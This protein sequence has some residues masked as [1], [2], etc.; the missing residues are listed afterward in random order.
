ME[1]FTGVLEKK[2]SNMFSN[3]LQDAIMITTGFSIE[4]CSLESEGNNSN[5]IVGAMVMCGERSVILTIS[6][7]DLSARNIV[8]YMTGIDLCELKTDMLCD[9]ITEIVNIIGGGARIAL[10][11]TEL[12]ISMTVP[13]TI[14]GTD[15][16]IVVKKRTERIIK[17]FCGNNIKLCLK[18]FEL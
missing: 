11:N 18:I 7:D 5:E 16:D 9:G 15:L 6:T 2:W 3:L 8:S 13:F 1:K 12:A 17:C 14:V 10:E 4:E